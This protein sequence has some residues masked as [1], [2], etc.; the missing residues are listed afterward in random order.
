MD[1]EDYKRKLTDVLSEDIVHNTRQMSADEATTV[2]ILTTYREIMVSLIKQHRGRV[3]DSPGEIFI[4]KTAFAPIESK[5][6]FRY[7]YMAEQ[8][9]K[10]IP[11][12]VGAYRVLMEPRVTAADGI[13]KKKG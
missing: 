12:P 11:K 4:S 13:E 8:S 10:K 2:N 6:P 3:V 1:A 5:L 9:V 7:E